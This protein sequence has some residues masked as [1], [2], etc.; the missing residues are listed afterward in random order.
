MSDKKI[1]AVVGATGAQ[2][3]GLVRAIMADPNGGFTARALTRDPESEGAKA[4][5]ALGAEVVAVDI[6]DEASIRKAFEGAYGAFCVTFFWAHS[7]PSSSRSRPPPWRERPR[8]AGS[9]TS[10]WSTLE[11]T[12]DARAAGRRPHADAAR[13]MEGPALRSKGST[14]HVFTDAGVPTTFLKRRSTG[15]TSSTSAWARSAARTASCASRSRSA[16][17]KMPGMAAEDIG[18]AAYGIFKGG[19][20]F[21][22]KTVEHRRRAPER[23]RDGRRRSRRRWAR[24]S[25]TTTVSPDV[26]RGFGF[27]GADDLGNMFQYK[28]D[29]EDSYRGA[30]RRRP[31]PGS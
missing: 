25:S 31:Q 1:I 8:R 12:R 10:I 9:S 18:K 3:G 14:N 21:I 22:G 6:D 15:R 11:D 28:R 13:E 5:A 19:D 16:S 24:T 2:G 26:Y 4:L 27:P 7:R 17:A 23:R 20:A 29:F 30:A